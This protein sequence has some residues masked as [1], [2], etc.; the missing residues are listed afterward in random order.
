VDIIREQV[1]QGKFKY[2][3]NVDDFMPL[4]P[5]VLA[6]SDGSAASSELA[7]PIQPT[8]KQD[9]EI[10][11]DDRNFYPPTVLDQNPRP[12]SVDYVRR[13]RERTRHSFE[14]VRQSFEASNDFTSAAMLHRMESSHTEAAQDPFKTPEELPAH[15]N[16]F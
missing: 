14:R 4:K 2:L 9:P 16:M 12:Q 15:N 11:D 1:T 8:M 10:P 6:N 7:K 13:S 5:D 3:E